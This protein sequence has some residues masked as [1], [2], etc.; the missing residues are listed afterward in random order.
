MKFSENAETIIKIIGAKEIL[1][2]CKKHKTKKIYIRTQPSPAMIA[3]FGDDKARTLSDLFGGNSV[4]IPVKRL[5]LKLRNQTI[6]E[7]KKLGMNVKKIEGYYSLSP[8]TIYKI[9]ASQ[10]SQIGAKNACIKK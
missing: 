2:F 6:T 10:R 9:I 5:E 4:N 7:L 8:Q 1:S 3:E